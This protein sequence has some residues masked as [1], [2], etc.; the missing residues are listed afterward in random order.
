MSKIDKAMKLMA[1][2]MDL[3]EIA[4][5]EQPMLRSEKGPKPSS[6]VKG[7]VQDKRTGNWGARTWKDGAPIWIGTFKTIDEASQA[8]DDFHTST[9]QIE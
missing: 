7:V 3:L 4:R 9:L 1:R 6:G 5:D 2:A 8:V